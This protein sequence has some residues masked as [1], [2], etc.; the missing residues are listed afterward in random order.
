M[1]RRNVAK[2]VDFGFVDHHEQKASMADMGK[3][4]AP[5]V[6]MRDPCTYKADIWALGILY[7]ELI[8]GKTPFEGLTHHQIIEHAQKPITFSNKFRQNEI[9]LINSILKLEP[10]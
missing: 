10:T 8:E 9:T 2:L 4:M 7:Y 5:E 3:Y 1:D 6:L